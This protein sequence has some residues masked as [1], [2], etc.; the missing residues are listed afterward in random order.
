MT[1]PRILFLLG[2]GFLVVNVLVLYQ[3]VRFRRLRQTA[4]L[5]WP[6]RRPPL[7]RLFLWVGALLGVLIIYKLAVLRL[8][9]SQVFGES[10]MLVYYVYTL[11]L[12][13][14]IRRGFYDDGIWTDTGFL[15]YANIGGLAWQEGPPVTLMVMYRWRAFARRLTV[16]EPLYGEA[17]RVLRDKIATH[18]IH[19]TGKSLDLGAHD[20]RDDV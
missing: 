18:D 10:M 2:G 19:F 3:Y 20:E 8:H 1:L 15:S 6:A 16:P 4:L 14:A 13:I 11:P 17:R 5:T 9:P 7:Y 12:S